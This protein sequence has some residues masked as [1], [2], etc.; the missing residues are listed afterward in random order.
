M[1]VA[2]VAAAHEVTEFGF[3]FGAGRSI[4]VDPV[5]ILVLGASIGE[6]LFV[7]PDAD[8]A[9]TFGVGALS[10]QRAGD[11]VLGEVSGPVAVAAAADG[12]GH[13]VGQ[14]TVS[15]SRSMAKRS[16]VNRPPGRGAGGWVLQRESMSAPALPALTTVSVMT[17]LSGST[18]TWPL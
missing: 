1:L 6:A 7:D 13:I 11:A 5:R 10:A 3:D 18:A 8:G 16:L 12:D 2:A 15:A 4:V 14:V 9:P 17:S